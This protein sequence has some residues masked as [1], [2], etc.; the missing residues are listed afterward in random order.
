MMKDPLENKVNKW[1]SQ[2][3]DKY[4]DINLKILHLDE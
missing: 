3:E 2:G 1:V 4:S